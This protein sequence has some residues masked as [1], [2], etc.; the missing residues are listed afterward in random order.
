MELPVESVPLCCQYVDFGDHIINSRS[1]CDD[2]ESRV[3]HQGEETPLDAYDGMGVAWSLSDYSDSPP[4]CRDEFLVIPLGLTNVCDTFQSGIQSWSFRLPF[5]DAL[6]RYN[7]TWED[8]VR[9]LDEPR[10]VIDMTKILHLGPGDNA[11][12][13]RGRLRDDMIYYR[14]GPYLVS[15]STFREM[16]MR[17]T[18]DTSWVGNSE[19]LYEFEAPQ[20]TGLFFSGVSKLQALPAYIVRSEDG[21]F[22]G[23]GWQQQGRLVG[24]GLIPSIWFSSVGGIQGSIY[25][26]SWIPTVIS[27]AQQHSL[28]IGSG[29]LPNWLWDPGIHLVGSLLHFLMD[30]VAPASGL[31]HS[32]I[33]M[34]G[35]ARIRSI[36]RDKFSLLVPRIRYGGGFADFGSAGTP[37]QIMLLD[38]RPSLYRY[39]STGFQEWGIQYVYIGQT[40]MARVV[41]RQHD[42][43]FP[44]LAW[45]PG[46]TGLDIALTDRDEWILAG[47]IIQ[48]F[49]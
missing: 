15:E 37:L 39:F 34:R 30:R 2:G 47:E 29:G 6:I 41:Q 16:V 32:W 26:L 22:L 25:W 23:A 10:A 11:Q 33:V 21:R 12:V 8:Y 38:S 3:D 20:E 31:L 28:G 14:D 5:L 24:T 48:I 36:W 40:V 13:D 42:D 44:R 4:M 7:R 17:V 43:P 45:D 49:H 19:N 9:Q 27:M 1:T 46:I 18:Y 35:L